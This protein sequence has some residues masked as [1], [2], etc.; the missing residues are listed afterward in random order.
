MV[1]M[2][3]LDIGS[4]SCIQQ[5]IT[6]ECGICDSSSSCQLWLLH[7]SRRRHAARGWQK[8]LHLFLGSSSC[9]LSH[10]QVELSVSKSESILAANELLILDVSCRSAISEGCLEDYGGSR[11]TWSNSCKMG[12]LNKSSSRDS[13]AFFWWTGGEKSIPKQSSFHSSPVGS[14]WSA[15]YLHTHITL[16]FN[17]HFSRWTWVSRL[18]P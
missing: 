1:F 18:P 9:W 12:P 16:R 4:T 14:P 7:L 5:S 2:C 13:A 6:D 3:Y 15:G 10:Q 8:L 11:L 17:G